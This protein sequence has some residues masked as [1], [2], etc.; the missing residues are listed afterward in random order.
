MSS[1]MV[2]LRHLLKD[3]SGDNPHPVQLPDEQGI[4]GS[5]LVPEERY[6]IENRSAKREENENGNNEK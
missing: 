2:Q 5:G 1:K 6:A 3:I 4:E